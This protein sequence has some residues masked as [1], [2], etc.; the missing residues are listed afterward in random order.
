QR[1]VRAELLLYMTQVEEHAVEILRAAA[2]IPFRKK[3]GLSIGTT[4]SNGELRTLLAG[5][6][7][8]DCVYMLPVIESDSK[9][10]PAREMLGSSI[11][12]F[13]MVTI[14]TAERKLIENQGIHKFLPL[15][16]KF[17]HS[18]Y[19]DLMRGCYVKRKSWFRR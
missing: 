7:Q 2:K 19:F 6:N 9:P 12:L 16:E 8:E 5:S 11:Q 14:S 3:Q 1:S 17:N 15:L 10:L 18:V 4:G 13:W